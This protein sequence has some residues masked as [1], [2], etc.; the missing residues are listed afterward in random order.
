MALNTILSSQKKCSS[1]FDDS[2][3]IDYT[4]GPKRFH[5]DKP[6]T[7]QLV[8]IAPESPVA[9][10][11]IVRFRLNSYDDVGA[12]YLKTDIT[13]NIS[14]TD[15]YAN[16]AFPGLNLIKR[17]TIM[18]GQNL[19][20]EVNNY[21]AMM[22]AQMSLMTRGERDIVNSSVNGI[23]SINPANDSTIA[24]I[25]PIP[26]IS[27]RIVSSKPF[28]VNMKN[29]NDGLIVEIEIFSR[30][31]FYAG[32]VLTNTVTEPSNMIMLYTSQVFEIN[33]LKSLKSITYKSID[34]ETTPI[35][36]SINKQVRIK[37]PLTTAI[38]RSCCVMVWCADLNQLASNAISLQDTEYPTRI[39]LL[40][41]S[42]VFYDHRFGN[43][44]MA[45]YSW[46]T[47][48][49][50][51]LDRY[52]DGK[53]S[54][55]DDD[56]E[57]VPNRNTDVEPTSSSKVTWIPLGV[58]SLTNEYAGGMVFSNKDTIE[59]V[60]SYEEYIFQ[61]DK[62]T[63]GIATTAWGVG[64]DY[65]EGDGVTDATVI[66]RCIDDHTS[67]VANQP[68]NDEF[69]ETFDYRVNTE[70]TNAGIAYRCIQDNIAST[71]NE[72]PNAG[73]WVL[74]GPDEFTA[75][76][77]IHNDANFKVSDGVMSRELCT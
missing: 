60:V 72:P 2:L 50:K 34:I 3:A 65:E 32:S 9:W 37:L 45:Y 63:D 49:L 26:F 1:I 24:C 33:T 36:E 61:R 67:A 38:K 54:V 8:E 52:S 23:S 41:N 53:D 51:S 71:A 59:I 5:T 25:T 76:V 18:D 35:I 43:A 21:Q 68:P 15:I 42:K 77:V 17:Y 22:Q 30:D 70:V 69:W 31:E 64:N 7:S 27:D 66:Y 55:V 14:D 4:D 11:Q 75:A 10:G 13:G 48:Y 19:L 57:D 62:W 16:P 56:G 73:F 58:S 46:Q 47:G 20:F 29:L 39:Q 40:V 28:Y 6:I 74:S 12:I 44:S